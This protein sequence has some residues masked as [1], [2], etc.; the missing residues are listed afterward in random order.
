MIP[1]EQPS[2]WHNCEREQCNNRK[3]KKAQKLRVVEA[4]FKNAA[5][6]ILVRPKHLVVSIK[7]N[8][9]IRPGIAAVSVQLLY[10]DAVLKIVI[11]QFIF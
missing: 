9:V 4:R 6:R 7:T 1:V 11:I 8:A 2:E 5:V 10:R 3:R